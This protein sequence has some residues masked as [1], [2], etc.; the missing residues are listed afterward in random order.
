MGKEVAAIVV[1]LLLQDVCKVTEVLVAPTLIIY[2]P[3]NI[4]LL[5]SKPDGC[6][7]VEAQIPAREDWIG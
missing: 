1:W 6:L 4:A 2:E 3:Q 7:V 5:L